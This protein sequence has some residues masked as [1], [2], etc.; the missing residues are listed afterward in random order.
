MKNLMLIAL[1]P[2][3][4]AACGSGAPGGTAPLREAT[5]EEAALLETVNALRTA[6]FT[7]PDGQTGQALPAYLDNALL[8]TTALKQAADNDQRGE[9]RVKGTYDSSVGV[10]IRLAGVPGR[11]FAA[12][13]GTLPFGASQ[14]LKNPEGCRAL[15]NARLT[16]AGTGIH[17]T[18]WV[19]D[20]MEPDPST[21]LPTQ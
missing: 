14:I 21:F 2:L 17:G 3:A 12:L 4:L 6:G 20:L 15:R 19:I 5:A 10:R 13:A 16:R 11:D 18:Y 9:V 7:C 1:L 8:N